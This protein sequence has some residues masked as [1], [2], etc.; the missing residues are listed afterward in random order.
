MLYLLKL[1]IF[2]HV[3]KWETLQEVR[4]TDGKEDTVPWI[5]YYCQCKCCGTI[6]HFE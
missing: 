5:R 4:V 1:L 2:G 3:H 6:R